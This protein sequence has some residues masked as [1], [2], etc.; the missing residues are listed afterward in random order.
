[1]FQVC[2]Y[3]LCTVPVDSGWQT[4]SG[5][6][7]TWYPDIYRHI[8]SYDGIEW[9]IEVYDGYIRIMPPSRFHTWGYFSDVWICQHTQHMQ[10]TWYAGLKCNENTFQKKKKMYMPYT[11]HEL[12]YT[13][14]SL[15]YPVKHQPYFESIF[16]YFWGSL[17]YLDLIGSTSQ[18]HCMVLRSWNLINHCS[19][20]DLLIMGISRY[21]IRM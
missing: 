20:S 12:L 18:T 4:S 5:I 19:D 21:M 13:C 11:C 17:R 15:A 16:P 8:P 14:H 9:Y 6:L 7:P 10:T 2:I 1:M 3:T